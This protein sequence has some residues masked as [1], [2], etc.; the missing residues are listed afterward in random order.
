MFF[1]E[2][3]NRN[4]T[5]GVFCIPRLRLGHKNHLGFY[6]YILPYFSKENSQDGWYLAGIECRNNILG[7]SCARGKAKGY[8]THHRY[9][10]YLILQQ[11]T[12]YDA[13]RES[14]GYLTYT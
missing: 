13:P 11:R 7:I 2:V 4:N 3:S 10:F 5:H 14:C 8:K 1:V 12:H 6:Y 9:Y